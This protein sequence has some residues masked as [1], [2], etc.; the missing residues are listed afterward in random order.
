MTT[1]SNEGDVKN[2]VIYPLVLAMLIDSR[3]LF[4]LPEKSSAHWLR[5]QVA[6]V[7]SLITDFKQ[8]EWLF[9]LLLNSPSFFHMID[10]N[11][12]SIDRTFHILSSDIQLFRCH[13]F[14]RKRSIKTVIRSSIMRSLMHLLILFLFCTVC[15]AWRSTLFPAGWTPAFRDP[16]VWTGSSHRDRNSHQFVFNSSIYQ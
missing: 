16:Q 4:K 3:I 9:L 2:I 13:D 7:T 5:L 8:L 1:V 6:R 14:I 15:S 11:Y 12:A 10:L